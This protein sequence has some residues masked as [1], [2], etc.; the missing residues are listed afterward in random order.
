M[1]RYNKLIVATV[2]LVAVIIGPDFF[3]LV[4]NTELFCAVS[5]SIADIVSC[6]SNP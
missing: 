5:D 2:G 1:S 6:V 3:N 4:D